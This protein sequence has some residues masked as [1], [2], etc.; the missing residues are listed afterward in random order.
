MDDLYTWADVA[1]ALTPFGRG[2]Q[3]AL[4]RLIRM[5]PSYLS[6]ELSKGTGE[7]TV[8]KAKEI[9]SAI[10]QLRT[11]EPEQPA[12]TKATPPR[13]SATRLPVYGYAAAGGEDRFVMNE[14]EVIEEVELPM[15]LSVGPG[16]YFVVIASGSSME[17]RI[18]SGE[19]K[20]VRRNYPATHGK[21]A[22]IEFKDGTAVIKIFRGRRDGRVFAE[23]FN[24]PKLLDYD[25]TTVKEVYPVVISL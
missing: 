12:P 19:R 6:R 10:I 18:F 17:P 16:E 3:V 8:T 4:A 9:A 24:P 25:A 23:Q 5:D 21:D 20:V 22:V 7:L 13:R 15:G 14:G 1:K 2:A 11:G